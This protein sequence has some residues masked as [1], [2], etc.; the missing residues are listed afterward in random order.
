MSKICRFR[1]DL[2]ESGFCV[3]GLSDEDSKK[4]FEYRW[5]DDDTFQIAV[6]GVWLDANS[7]DF[8]F[9]TIRE[10]A[11]AWWQPLT[12]KEKQE[13]LYREFGRRNMDLNSAAIS[14]RVIERMYRGVVFGTITVEDLINFLKKFDPKS[15]VDL[16]NDG[17]EWE[18]KDSSSK[19]EVISSVFTTWSSGGKTTIIIEN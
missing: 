6:E 15:E 2:L 17:W 5:V 18:A 10:L 1:K 13:L 11:I 19:D 9:P 3:P 16:E 7:V 14:G 4:L 8:E 12:D